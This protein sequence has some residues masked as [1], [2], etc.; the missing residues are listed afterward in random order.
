[1]RQLFLASSSPRRAELLRQIGVPFTLL[2]AP[3]VDESVYRHE[4]PSDYVRRLALAKA[5]TGWDSLRGRHPSL[6]A[7]AVVLGADT[8][9]V[10]GDAILGKPRGA[11]EAKSMLQRLSGREH[12]VL[13]AV[14][15]YYEEQT[16]IAMSDTV[17]RFQDLTEALIDQ[18]VATGEAFDKAGSYGIQGFGAVLVESIQG[19]YSG[20][21]GLP[22]TETMALL[23]V[24]GIPVWQAVDSHVSG[25]GKEKQ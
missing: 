20:V 21:V 8:S 3:G 12:R 14:S 18:Y 4:S 23:S 22:L 5:S 9:V 15:I 7:S 16:S 2:N 24:A 19:S 25:L 13:S 11:T 1:M 17:V 10:L 6:T